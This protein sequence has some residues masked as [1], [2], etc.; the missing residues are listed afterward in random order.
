MDRVAGGIIAVNTK[1]MH[2]S[3]GTAPRESSVIN[4]NRVMIT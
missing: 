2:K 3:L 1:Q 4:R